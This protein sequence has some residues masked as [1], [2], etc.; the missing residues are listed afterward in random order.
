MADA[1]PWWASEDPWVLAPA[2]LEALAARRAKR[3]AALE[4]LPQDPPF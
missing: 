4:A 3:E 2:E 1:V